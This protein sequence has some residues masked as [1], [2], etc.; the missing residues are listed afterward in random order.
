M[1][2]ISEFM[3]N[4]QTFLLKRLGFGILE[5]FG[6]PNN[7]TQTQ[8]LTCIQMFVNARTF[9]Y[10]S[11]FDFNLTRTDALVQKAIR[12]CFSE[13]TVITIAHRL[14]TIMDADRIMVKICVF[15]VK[16]N[17]SSKYFQ[18][19]NKGTIERLFDGQWTAFWSPQWSNDYFIEIREQTW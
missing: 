9:S 14:H 1:L 5:F 16:E 11:W 8:A 12:E 15:S 6:R 17:I 7:S 2:T 19:I 13:C 4:A 10:H 18:N 3:S